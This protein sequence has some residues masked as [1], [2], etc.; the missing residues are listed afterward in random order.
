MNVLLAVNYEH[1]TW[2]RLEIMVTSVKLL[3]GKKMR[4]LS[5]KILFLVYARTIEQDD[6]QKIEIETFI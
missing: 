1:L 4:D 5:H 6:R 3:Y 2:L